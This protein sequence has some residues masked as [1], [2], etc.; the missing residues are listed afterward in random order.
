MKLSFIINKG[1]DNNIWGGSNIKCFFE[2]Y[3]E[4][5]GK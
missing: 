3:F 4:N 2:N 1:Q 5:K